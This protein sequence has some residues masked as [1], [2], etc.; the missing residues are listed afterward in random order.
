MLDDAAFARTL[1]AHKWRTARWGAPR[2][3]QALAARR[4]PPALARAALDAL[5]ADDGDAGGD[6]AQQQLLQA[7]RRRWHLSRGLE[8]QAR[9]QG[10]ARISLALPDAAAA[11]R[12]G[13]GGWWAG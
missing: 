8:F 6:D 13:S 12:R 4:V 2:I 3:A 7:A 1:S 10:V 5:F 9:T 11:R